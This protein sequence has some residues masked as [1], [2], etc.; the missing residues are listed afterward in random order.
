MIVCGIELKASDAI[1]TIVK[2]ENS[3]IHVLHN[4]KKIPLGDTES[5]AAIIDFKEAVESF[6]KV[7]CIERVFIKKRATKGKFA[8]G[9]NTFKM[10]GLIQLISGPEIIL[11]SPQSNAAFSKKNEVVYPDSLKKYQQESFLT[12][13]TGMSK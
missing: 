6:F 13:L 3:N 5:S 2:Q 12:A 7:N 4:T 10:E 11:I 8:G 9:S 1:V